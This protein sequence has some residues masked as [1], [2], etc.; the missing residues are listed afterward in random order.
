MQI[1][2]TDRLLAS[3]TGSPDRPL[4]VL[5]LPAEGIQVPDGGNVHV[6]PDGLI[7]TDPDGEPYFFIHSS[8][9]VVGR[10]RAEKP[11]ARGRPSGK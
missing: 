3:L 10:Q 9:V 4:K 6:S 1:G 5:P 7:V 8:G 11:A 2:H